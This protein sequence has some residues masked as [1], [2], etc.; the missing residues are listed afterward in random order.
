[1]MLIM[2][3]RGTASSSRRPA[4]RRRFL[5]GFEGG[6]SHSQE[7][8]A[9]GSR[10]ERPGGDLPVKSTVP[11]TRNDR[12]ACRTSPIRR[13]SIRPNEIPIA[14]DEGLVATGASRVLEIADLPRKVAGIDVSKPGPA[15]DV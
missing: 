15:A 1:M 14:L 12:L 10:K 8:D 11:P 4:L 2:T 13:Q 3:R 7:R 9:T 5:P 6:P